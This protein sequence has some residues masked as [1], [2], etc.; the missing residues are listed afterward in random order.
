MNVEAKD[1]DGNNVE[2]GMSIQ[3]IVNHAAKTV[4]KTLDKNSR[5]GLII[6][7]QCY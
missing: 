7:R 4:A 6:F 2:T 5:L 1:S 3:D